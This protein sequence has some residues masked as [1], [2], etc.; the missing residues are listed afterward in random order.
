MVFYNNLIENLLIYIRSLGVLFYEMLFGKCPYE[1]KSIANL[2]NLI[3]DTDLVFHE[4]HQISETMRNLL[5][6][7]LCKDPQRR[8]EWDR[9][10]DIVME[11]NTIPKKMIE[12]DSIYSEMKKPFPH[13]NVSIPQGSPKKFDHQCISL[14]NTPSIELNAGT[15]NQTILNLNTEQTF[16]KPKETSYETRNQNFYKTE[17]PNSFKPDHNSVFAKEQTFITPTNNYNALP[18]E[19][20]TMN[21]NPMNQMNYSAN[22]KNPLNHQISSFENNSSRNNMKN[23]FKNENYSSGVKN[24]DSLHSSFHKHEKSELVFSK[25]YKIEIKHAIFNIDAL[26]KFITKERNKLY[27]LS[28]VFYELSLYKLMSTPEAFEINF[29]KYLY[30]HAKNFKEILLEHI[31]LDVVNVIANYNDL[32]NT[33]EYKIVKELF[34]EEMDKIINAFMIHKEKAQLNKNIKNIDKIEM[35]STNY[36]NLK[37][38]YKHILEYIVLV[39]ENFLFSKEEKYKSEDSLKYMIHVIEMLDSVL[40]NEL[41]DNFIEE[42]ENFDNQKYFINLRKSK[43]TGLLKILNQ[44]IDYFK[45]K[46]IQE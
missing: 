5:R 33:Y 32:C 39:K 34:K 15:F 9:I 46:Y 41:F 42:E 20:S 11:K 18:S 44:K 24:R 10:Y 16:N 4:N 38:F 2:I 1:G 26:L 27:F 35:D 7:M 30:F 8:I 40:L 17:N 37:N 6:E 19:N 21:S 13:L 14:D 29:H 23:E 12:E 43:F 28:K 45:K 36:I 3:D 22:Q 25:V 31:S